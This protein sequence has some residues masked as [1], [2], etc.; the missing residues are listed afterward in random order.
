ML[1]KP[2]HTEVPIHPLM[3]ERWSPRA[4][5]PS[6]RLAGAEIASILEAGRW[7]PSCFGDQPWRFVLFEKAPGA[8]ATF[9][10]VLT[11]LTSKNRLWVPQASL[12]VLTVAATQFQAGPNQ[13]KPNRFAQYD[14]GA[15]VMSMV[16]QAQSLS[17]VAHQ[18]AGFDAAAMRE[19]VAVPG[20]Y[21]CMALVAFG[22]QATPDSVAQE[23]RPAEIAP[24]TRSPVGELAFAGRW[25]EPAR[26]IPRGIVPGVQA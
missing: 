26:S 19:L 2:A 16:L 8:D 23:L 10:S 21:E 11:T 22:R 25:G 17:L 6:Y 13:G 7:A 15:A 9:G 18:M 5:D 3:A 24:R 12:L 4:F 14:C 20:E 1:S